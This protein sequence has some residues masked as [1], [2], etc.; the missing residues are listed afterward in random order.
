VFNYLSS[1]GFQTAVFHGGLEEKEKTLLLQNFR[2]GVIK[3]VAATIA[4][5]MGLDFENLDCVIHMNMP[6]SVESYVQEIGRA[7]RRGKRAFCHMFLSKQDYM[8]NRNFILAERLE[9]DNIVH[10]VNEI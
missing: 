5:G 6:K 1:E 7:G 9:M 3:V 2:T 4:L 10:F 8:T